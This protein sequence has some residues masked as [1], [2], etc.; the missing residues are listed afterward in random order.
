MQTWTKGSYKITLNPKSPQQPGDL[1]IRS[2][3][4]CGAFGI[5]RDGSEWSLSHLPSGLHIDNYS[6]KI[7]A[8]VC[9]VRLLDLAVDWNLTDPLTPVSQEVR[10]KY[11]EV[12]MRHS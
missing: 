10:D 7:A 11:K 9:V 8:E 6:S 1:G 5:C 12:R 3:Y 4:V 2:G